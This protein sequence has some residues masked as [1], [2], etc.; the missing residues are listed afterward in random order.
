MLLDYHLLTLDYAVSYGSVTLKS[1]QNDNTPELDLLVRESI[2]NSSDASL[3]EPGD[4]YKVAFT[5][6][7]FVP[8]DFNSLIT[9]LEDELNKRYPQDTASFMEIR[10]TKTSGLTG[11]IRKAE[12]TDDDHGN[13]FK[14]IYDTG[15]KQTQADAGG[16]WGFGKSVY[17]RVGIGIVVFYSRVKTD[18]GS[19][20]SRLIVTVVE[21]ENKKD[22]AGNNITLL[23]S[24]EPRS[25]G[26]AWWGIR[27][28]EDL[29]PVTDS[30]FINAVLDAFHLKPF[31][32]NE[33]GTSIII[34]YIDNDRLLS[35]IIPQEAEIREDVKNAFVSLWGTQIEDYLRLAI[36]RWYAPKIHNRKLTEICEDKKWLN[37]SVNNKALRKTDLL[38]FFNL[39]QELYNAALAKNYNY[40]YTCRIPSE[41]KCYPVKIRGYL[42]GSITGYVAVTRITE[43]ELSGGSIS[44]SPYDYVGRFEADGG[45]NEPIVMFTREPGMIIDYPVAG[46]WVK[47]I[48]PP[49]SESEYLFAFYMP[50]TKK[51]LKSDL[52]VKEYAGKDLGYYLRNCE[53]SDHMNWVDPAQ[54]RI[55][56]R[57]QINIVNQIEKQRAAGEEKAVEAT[58]SKLSGKLG[59]LFMPRKGYGKHSSVPGGGSGG[60]SGIRLKDLEFIIRSTVFENSILEMSYSL[61]LKH[62]KKKAM[63]YLIVDSEGGNIT[64]SSW[65][66]DIGTAFPADIIELSVDMINSSVFPEPLQIN[67]ICTKK[68]TE[69]RGEYFSVKLESAEQSEE[70]TSV[71]IDSDIF[72]IELSGKIRIQAEDKKYR[73]SFRTV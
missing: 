1:L 6:D 13:F 15:K 69:Y 26:K 68:N 44:L 62:Q 18:D 58:A 56:N 64:P 67:G 36:Q 22:E 51:L 5:T 28:G 32:D 57:I 41:V 60:E 63:V 38:P 16:N 31:R 45:I 46:P 39:V 35:D 72:N 19:F 9:G 20:E 47:G 34:P 23:H 12:I 21:D 71:S 73:F 50:D 49:E 61:K 4:S 53:A 40:D 54:M 42:D 11:C 29:L 27:D 3:Q 59:R 30:E 37:V 24:L 14:L 7:T 52:P 66:K 55:V 25:Q 8:K 10:D 65:Q 48:T 17:Y 33:T 70:L 43:E 2:Q